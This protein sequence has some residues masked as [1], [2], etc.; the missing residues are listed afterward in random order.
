MLCTFYEHDTFDAKLR[1]SMNRKLRVL[2]VTYHPWRE[3][4]SVGNT[5][6]NIFNNMDDQLEF[7]NIYIRDDKPCNRIVKHFFNISEKGL[8]KSV[9][10][11]TKV[12]KVAQAVGENMKKEN[13]SAAYNAARRMRWD[14]MLLFQDMK[15][16][17]WNIF[18]YYSFDNFSTRYLCSLFLKFLTVDYCTTYI[19]ILVS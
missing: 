9:F 7:A 18:F 16:Q 4:I 14:I 13:F 15:A 17:F 10:F 3:D 6:S 11:R 8:A 12:G 1:F 2:V 19:D 5:L